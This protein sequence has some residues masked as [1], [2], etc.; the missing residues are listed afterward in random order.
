VIGL[1]FIAMAPEVFDGYNLVAYRLTVV[2]D[3]YLESWFDQ[4]P[5]RF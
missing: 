1:P 5:V 4:G 3:K 2:P